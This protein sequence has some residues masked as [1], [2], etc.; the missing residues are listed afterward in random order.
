LAETLSF[1]RLQQPP[2]IERKPPRG[3]HEQHLEDVLWAAV[4]ILTF[5]ALIV[6]LFYLFPDTGKCMNLS[7]LPC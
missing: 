5:L 6:V 1:K 7:Y 4:G 3:M 2:Q